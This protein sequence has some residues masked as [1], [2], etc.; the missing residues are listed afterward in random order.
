MIKV[1]RHLNKL[2]VNIGDGRPL[3]V[4]TPED[5]ARAVLHYYGAPHDKATCPFCL[6]DH[7]TWK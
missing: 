6:A 5:A 2:K 7:L 3:L 4:D 1:E